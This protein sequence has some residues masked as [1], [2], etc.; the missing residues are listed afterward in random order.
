[1]RWLAPDG[2]DL[3]EKLFALPLPVKILRIQQLRL[4]AIDYLHT[5]QKLLTTAGGRRRI[6][7]AL[8]TSWP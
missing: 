4:A 1:M 3:S 5:I 2:P 8:K 7:R 6:P